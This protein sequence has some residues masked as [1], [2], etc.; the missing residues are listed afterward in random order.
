MEDILTELLRYPAIVDAKI[1][2]MPDSDWTCIETTWFTV[3]PN[4]YKA[5][6]VSSTGVHETEIVTLGFP[7]SYPAHAPS[8]RLRTDFPINLPHIDPHQKGEAVPPCVSEVPLSEL[9]HSLGLFGILNAIEEWLK[10]AASNELHDPAQG[11][12]PIRRT[13]ANGIL[14]VNAFDLRQQITKHRKSVNYFRTR[15]TKI[16]NGFCFGGMHGDSLGSDNNSLMKIR[17]GYSAN[18]NFSLTPAI[19]IANQESCEVYQADR[20]GTFEEL[21]SFA[22]YF[23]LNDLLKVRYKYLTKKLFAAIIITMIKL[24]TT[25]LLCWQLNDLTLSLVSI[26]TLN[27]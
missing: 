26:V 13:D 15:Y 10:N 14:I 7:V 16:S 4:K 2:D 19:V 3:L 1:I 21:I 18:D 6:G 24:S 27:Y 22:K 12:E 11:W 20:V 9:L 25:F 23:S 5:K 8:I 17:P